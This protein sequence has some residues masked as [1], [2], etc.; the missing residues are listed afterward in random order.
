MDKF[1]I[2]M[3]NYRKKKKTKLFL[4]INNID[5]MLDKSS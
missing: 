3:E 4:K 5:V 1:H 2:D